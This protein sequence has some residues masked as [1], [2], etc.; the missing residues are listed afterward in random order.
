MA[1]F[2]GGVLWLAQRNRPQYAI[3]TAVLAATFG[4]V[5]L[6]WRM[7]PDLDRVVSARPLWEKIRS[8]PDQYCMGDMHRNLRYGLNYY[9]HQPLP[10]CQDEPGLKRLDGEIW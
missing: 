1:A 5:Y 9:S 10:A 4:V 2:A 6:K 8:D 3:A 7:F